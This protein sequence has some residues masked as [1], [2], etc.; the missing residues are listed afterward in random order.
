MALPQFVLVHAT[1]K[2]IL[3]VPLMISGFTTVQLPCKRFSSCDWRNRSD[4]QEISIETAQSTPATTSCGEKGWVS[5]SHKISTTNGARISA[6]QPMVP[7]D[8]HA[9]A[10]APRDTNSLLSQ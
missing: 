2:A 5:H 6:V 8:L 9:P 7:S 1:A 10:L 4:C 3:R